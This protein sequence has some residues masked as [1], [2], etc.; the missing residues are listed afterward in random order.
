MLSVSSV[1]FVQ[2]FSTTV[3][4]TSDVLIIHVRQSFAQNSYNVIDLIMG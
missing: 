1:Q 2:L 4:L 3:G